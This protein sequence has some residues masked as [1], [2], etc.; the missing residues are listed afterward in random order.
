MSKFV[1]H[2]QIN[3]DFEVKYEAGSAYKKACIASSTGIIDF[4]NK[5]FN[6]GD[7]QSVKKL[8]TSAFYV[9]T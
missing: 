9:F 8:F 4:T 5:R 7:H 3:T 1:N 2:Y 6:N